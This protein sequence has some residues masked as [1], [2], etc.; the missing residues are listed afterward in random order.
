MGYSKEKQQ[1]LISALTNV[2]SLVGDNTS[3]V[4]NG[5]AGLGMELEQTKCDNEAKMVRDGLFKVAIMGTFSCGKSTVINALVG[6]KIL[7]ESA[8]PCT[9]IL[10]FI[11]YGTDESKAEVY[12]ADEVRPDGSVKPGECIYMSVDD[13]QN[14]YKYT[15]EDEKEFAETGQVERFAKVKYAVMYCSKPLM[16]GGV[17]IID[18][19]GLEDKQVATDLALKIAGESQAIIFVVPERG[20]SEDDKEYLSAAFRNCPNNVFFLLNK[21]DLVE[22]SQR[23]EAMQK[24]KDDTASVF[25]SEKGQL[26][27]DLQDRRCFGISALRAIDARRG[28]T[29]DKEN[30]EEC[31][32]TA[33]EREKK[34]NNSWFVPFE[35]ELEHFLTTDE[36]CVAQYQ[37]CFVKMA[38]AYKSA[39][40]QIDDYISAYESELQLDEE[41]KGE[42]DRIIADIRTS[43]K[44]TETTFDNCSLRIQNKI[45]EVMNACGK[46]IDRSW[47]QD[48]QQLAKK[49]DISTLSYMWTGIKMMF[50]S[51]DTRKKRM[52]EF[53]GKFITVVTDYFVEKVE[54]YISENRVVIDQEVKECQRTLN[55]SIDNTDKLFDDLAR[56]LTNG[57]G[58]QPTE[59]DKSWLQ[60]IISSYL[61]DFSAALKG[62]TDGKSS[63]M[64]Y[65]KKTL[66]NT[67]W[68]A[69]LISLIDGGLGVLVAISIEYFQGASNK[70]DTV[71]KI[72]EKS[73][74]G[75]VKTIR[76]QTSV[77]CDNINKQVAVEINNKKTEMTEDMFLK[78]KDEQTKMENII[79]SH[80]DH[81]FNLES[82]KQRFEKILDSIYKE[83]KD[84]YME[85]FGSDLSLSQFKAM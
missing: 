52:E 43:I 11:Q 82:E 31:P 70:N 20:M 33:A 7:P 50:A 61:G 46:N 66:F 65:L 12:M 71:K 68:Q 4:A 79:R 17:T 34:L 58:V 53:T 84:A 48:M 80:T 83:A 67:I 69:V 40:S 13:F 35:K 64:E 28:V 54:E 2:G 74:E 6:S 56:Q 76:D 55:V 10:T 49:V 72:L 51:G 27:K 38:S 1:K 21:F 22:K 24:L 16:E 37:N 47:D 3:S 5:I 26:N 29:Y 30:E 15:R 78:L 32:L 45:S 73:K 39:K 44:V 41:K 14:E 8:L 81:N 77:M 59:T 42:C 18:A 62:A 25:T 23:E 9:A 57:T 75:I 19:P 85:V 60:I 63:W 36:K